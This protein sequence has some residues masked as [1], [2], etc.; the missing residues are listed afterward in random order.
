[1]F[2]S[3]KNF[4]ESGVGKFKPAEIAGMQAYL[5]YPKYQSDEWKNQWRGDFNAC[6]G[7]RGAP[8]EDDMMDSVR[9]YPVTPRKF[10]DPFSGSAEAI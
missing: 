4:Y 2:D 9:V 3:D 5:P 8:L 6:D 1:M 7:P 10:P